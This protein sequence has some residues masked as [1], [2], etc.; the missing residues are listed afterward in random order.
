VA[1]PTET[2][3]SVNNTCLPC[4]A[5][6]ILNAGLTCDVCPLGE[7]PNVDVS[8]CVNCPANTV[9]TVGVC[10]ACPV[11]TSISGKTC[12]PCT[13]GTFSNDGISCVVCPLGETPNANASAC[14]RCSVHSISTI[15][16]CTPCSTGQ[17]AN[18]VGDECVRMTIKISMT[19]STFSGS[20]SGYLEGISPR[21][22]DPFGLL[23]HTDNLYLTDGDRIRKLSLT[24]IASLV[25]GTGGRGNTNGDAIAEA[26][27]ASPVSIVFD[28]FNNMFV[29]VC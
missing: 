26:S 24:G 15:G 28:S 29:V 18:F 10:A 14:V 12:T 4:I 6:S 22:F 16:I 3:H 2:P 19:V 21:Y 1:C 5:G 13:A 20:E 25:A 11:G 23:F 9:S 17:T 27:F 7:T 8:A